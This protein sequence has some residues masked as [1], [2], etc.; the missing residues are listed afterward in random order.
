MESQ[1]Q[2]VESEVYYWHG[3][4][5]YSNVTVNCTVC[6]LQEALFFLGKIAFNA[7]SVNKTSSASLQ[8]CAEYRLQYS[9]CVTSVPHK[10]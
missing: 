10:H 6:H 7:N 4:Y 8:H 5:S 3:I 1:S 9:I 2:N